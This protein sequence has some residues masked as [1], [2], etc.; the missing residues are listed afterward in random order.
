MKA[1]RVLFL[2]VAILGLMACV[3]KADEWDQKTIFTFSCARRDSRQSAAA[4]NVRVQARRLRLGSKHR[5]S[6]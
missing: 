5:S 4:G 6:V 3:A 1:N 2:G